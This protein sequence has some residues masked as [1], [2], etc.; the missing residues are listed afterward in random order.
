[1]IHG[2]RF[3]LIEENQEIWEKYLNS[4]MDE[5]DAENKEQLE[6]QVY[7]EEEKEKNI[8]RLSGYSEKGKN[9][10]TPYKFE[11]RRKKM[12][13]QQY[14]P[15]VLDFEKIV[16]KSFHKVSSQD[17]EKFKN[18]T[19]KKNK[20]NHLNAFLLYCVTNRIIENENK[21]FLILLLPE[22]YRNVGKLLAGNKLDSLLLTEEEK[23]I[24]CPFCKQEKEAISDNWML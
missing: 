9:N 7:T 16:G 23:K 3:F 4:I 11:Y 22:L 18:T 5:W 1:M 12:S 20:L 14:K 6:K 2:E 24:E 21:D 19:S 15:I 17:V 10:L 8:K 13:V